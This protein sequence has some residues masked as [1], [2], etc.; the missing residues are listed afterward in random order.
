MMA[1]TRQI[2]NDLRAHSR[3]FEGTHVQGTMMTSLCRSLDRAV[4]ELERLHDEVTLLR[5]F[6]EIPQDAP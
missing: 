5:A 4:H 1:S 6:A 3:A 2:I